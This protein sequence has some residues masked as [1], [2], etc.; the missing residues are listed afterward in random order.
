MTRRRYA[1]TFSAV[2]ITGAQDPLELTP[3]DDIPLALIGWELFQTSDHGDAQAE[4][5]SLTVIRGHTVGGSGG[6]SVTPAP[7]DPGDAA[8]SF[9]AKVNNTT[10]ASSGTTASLYAGGWNLQAG[11]EKYFPEE[12]R[13]RVK[14]SNTTLV[15]RMSAPADSIT[16]NGVFWVEEG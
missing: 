1:I 11:A 10:V 14:Q 8:A 2:A 12:L 15:V 4:G 3:A 9:T 13:P 5:L 6:T 16:V 7:L